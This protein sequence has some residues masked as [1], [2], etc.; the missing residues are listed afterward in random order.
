[1]GGTGATRWEMMSSERSADSYRVILCHV[2]TDM[3][4]GRTY[5]IRVQR[6]EYKR[7]Q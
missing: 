6:V 7:I 2:A 5:W 4:H 1:M 3:L